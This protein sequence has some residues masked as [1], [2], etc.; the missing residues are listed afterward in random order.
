MSFTRSLASFHSTMCFVVVCCK[1]KERKKCERERKEQAGKK[2]CDP[3]WMLNELLKQPHRATN[4]KNYEGKSNVSHD[5]YL[6]CVFVR[7]HSC[8]CCCCYYCPLY[9]HCQKTQIHITLEPLWMWLCLACCVLLCYSICLNTAH[10]YVIW[11]EKH[12]AQSPHP[13]QSHTIPCHV[14]FVFSTYTHFPSFTFF[15][16]HFSTLLQMFFSRFRSRHRNALGIY[17]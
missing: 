4:N 2:E 17:M 13:M 11:Q 14:H 10:T 5:R 12:L 1:A 3:E 9:V 8:R 6:F 16:F 15:L 7:S